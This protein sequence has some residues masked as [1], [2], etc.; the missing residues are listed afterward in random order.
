ML[1]VKYN[2][3]LNK[4]SIIFIAIII[5]GLVIGGGLYGYKILKS[6][7]QIGL[8]NKSQTNDS[9]NAPKAIGGDKDEHGCLIAA[10]YS[11]CEAKQKCLRIW[12]EPCTEEDVLRNYL[13]E[14][15]SQLSPEKEVLGGKFYVTKVT[16]ATPGQAEVEYEDGHIALK[17]R[18]EYSVKQ[19]VVTIEKFEIMNDE[20][21]DTDEIKDA[22]EQLFAEK[23]NKNISDISISLLQQDGRHAR[24]SVKFAPEGEGGLFLAVAI[25]DKWQ[26]IFDG[27]GSVDCQEIMKYG[28]TEAMLTGICY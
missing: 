10:G 9:A 25:E 28:F 24:G 13:K 23:Y 12:E 7:Q 19:D 4:K 22:I 8:V 6:K 2:S 15:I 3:M 17:A 5:L 21:K 11:W 26:L 14:N 20:K 1:L 16:I 18:F 27:N